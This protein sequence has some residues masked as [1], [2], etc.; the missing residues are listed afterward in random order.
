MLTDDGGAVGPGREGLLSAPLFIAGWADQQHG[1]LLPRAD[2]G[3]EYSDSA[4]HGTD[5]ERTVSLKLTGILT[6]RIIC[7]RVPLQKGV[8]H[9]YAMSS[10][11]DRG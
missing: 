3:S 11:S 6:Q 10:A 5:T 8:H 4:R 7:V 2:G 9:E 1:R